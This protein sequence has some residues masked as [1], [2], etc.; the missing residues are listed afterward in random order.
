MQIPLACADFTFPLLEH[1]QSLDL[2]ALLKFE[3]VDIGLFEGRSH[4]WPS[5]EFKATARSARQLRKKLDERG[6]RAADIF[7]QTNPDFTPYAINHPQAARRRKAREWFLNTLEYAS[8]CGAKHVSALPGVFFA[9]ETK[10]ASWDRACGELAWRIERAKEH[11]VIFGVEPHVGSIA[12]KPKDAERLVR[13]VPGLTLTLDYTHFARQG[14]A[15][16]AVE[17]LVKHA[18]HFHTRGAR[19]GRLQT[20]FKDN[21]I[22]YR[23]VLDVMRATGYRGYLGIEY[24]WI[25]WEHCNEVDNISETILFR[26]FI[27]GYLSGRGAT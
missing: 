9:D 2:I 8:V 22:D 4:L 5:W 25:N 27:R 26:D 18:T 20:S 12:P 6:L 3:G 10:A 21:A 7:L 16:S 15:D 14:I 24:V 1:E 13:S 11:E 19:K 23:R 17:P